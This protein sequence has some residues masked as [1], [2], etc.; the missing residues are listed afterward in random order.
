[1]LLDAEGRVKIADF[2]IA[3]LLED[4][5]TPSTGPRCA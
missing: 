2:G 1:L 5:A 3:K 4:P